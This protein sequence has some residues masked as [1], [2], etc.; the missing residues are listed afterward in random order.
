MI[1]SYRFLDNKCAS[2]D[3]NA[4]LYIGSTLFDL[5]VQYL[6]LEQ[7]LNVGSATW[8]GLVLNH[9]QHRRGILLSK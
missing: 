2:A 3:F 4:V 7:L 5:P 8:R 1:S 6:V 9:K